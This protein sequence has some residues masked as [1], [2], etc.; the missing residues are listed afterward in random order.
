M[1]RHRSGQP[2]QWSTDRAARAHGRRGRRTALWVGLA[3]AGVLATA[4]TVVAVVARPPTEP[5]AAVSVSTCD[6]VLR[7]VTA[8]SFTPVLEAVA[9]TLDHGPDCVGLDTV[10]VD[11]REA[12]ARVAEREADL[13]IPDD[14]SWAGLARPGLLPDEDGPGGAGTVL[15]TSPIYLVTDAGTAARLRSAGGSWLGLSGLLADRTSGVRLAVRDP[16]GSGDGMVAAGSLG[17]AVWLERGMDASSAA[18]SAALPSTRTVPGAGPALPD[19]AGEVGLVPE[20]ALVPALAEEKDA[21]I[22]AGADHTALLRYTWL[23]TTAAL[24]TPERAAALGKLL[25]ALKGPEAA[26]AIGAAHLRRPGGTAPPGAPAGRL[27]QLTGKPL[28]PLGAHHVDHVFA[29]WYVQDRRSSI[30]LAVDV[31]G[32]MLEPAPGTGTPLIDFVRQGCLAVGRLLPDQSSLG[33]WAFGSQLDPPRDYK[34]LLPTAPLSEG[35]RAGLTG[36]VGQL[37]ARRTGTG[38][39]DTIL[40][41]YRSATASYR[42]DVGN[43]VVVFSDGLNQDDPN[44]ISSEQLAS[45]LKAAADPKRPVQITV[46]AYGSHPE[47]AVLQKALAPVNAY[48]SKVQTAE[49]V[50][51][52]FLHAAASGIH[53]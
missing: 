32:S 3:V 53:S 42:E 22:L 12:A 46:V 2:A 23:P 24:G 6:Q 16:N 18:L 1:G 50:A 20:Y 25:A 30:L 31:S 7:V 52:A 8:T 9:A 4:S 29:A 19:R 47:A 28:E 48:V 45:A 17:E 33:L 43:Q 5:P 37:V 11:G 36:A 26:A 51:A 49:Q 38:L 40:A 10:A 39:Y 34:V 27:P 35:Q 41:A 13:W 14:G 15:A 21:V 44:S